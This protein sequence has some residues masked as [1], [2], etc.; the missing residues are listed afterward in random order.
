MLKYRK[1]DD[2]L[3]LQRGTLRVIRQY[4]FGYTK[5]G[6][7]DMLNVSQGTMMRIE[8]PSCN[9]RKS[10]YEKVILCY[11]RLLT[12]LGWKLERPQHV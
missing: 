3:E 7:A 6:A 1:A 4:I 12:E 10:T 5:K 2:T 11:H 8:K 9:I